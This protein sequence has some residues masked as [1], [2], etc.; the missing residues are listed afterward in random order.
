MKDLVFGSE[1]WLSELNKRVKFPKMFVVHYGV[2]KETG[3]AVLSPV[4]V[5]TRS[6]EPKNIRFNSASPTLTMALSPYKWLIEGIYY[7]ESADGYLA[8]MKELGSH[9]NV[10]F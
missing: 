2:H 3:D 4:I 10:K 7:I 9:W 6:T 5:E 8:K 1:E